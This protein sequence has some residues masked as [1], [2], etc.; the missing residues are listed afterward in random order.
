MLRQRPVNISFC[1]SG[2][3]IG[4][5]DRRDFG[6]PGFVNLDQAVKIVNDPNVVTVVFQPGETERIPVEK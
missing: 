5:P 1:F 2:T 6:R 4:A 3:A